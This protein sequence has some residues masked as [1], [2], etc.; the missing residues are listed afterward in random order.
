MLTIHSLLGMYSLKQQPEV[1]HHSCML[2][3]QYCF[4][5]LASAI[6]ARS[7]LCQIL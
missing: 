7:K 2:M 6:T 4:Q 1:V 3:K 5:T